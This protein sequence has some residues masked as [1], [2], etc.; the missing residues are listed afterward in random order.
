[1]TLMYP[2]PADHA[3]PGV[4]PNYAAV[5]GTTNW[6]TFEAIFEHTKKNHLDVK[7]MNN[8]LSEV[9]LQLIPD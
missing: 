2:N 9:F 5:N 7:N 6:V 4:I 3:D 8:A 1:M